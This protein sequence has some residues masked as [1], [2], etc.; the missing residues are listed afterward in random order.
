MKEKLEKNKDKADGNL[1]NINGFIREFPSKIIQVIEFS[2]YILIR[3][4]YNS[5]I[6][7]NIFCI[8]YENKI[9]WN[10]SE[11]IES[12]KEAYTEMN[13]ISENI[14]EVSLFIGINYKIDIIN[15]K[16]LEKRIVK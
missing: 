13:K 15:K 16:I 2:N 8:N 9:I 1:L 7:N 10:I 4:E 6:L 11:I 14:V 5:L 12:D 3:L